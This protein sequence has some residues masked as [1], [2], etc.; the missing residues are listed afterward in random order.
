MIKHF[1][2][3]NIDFKLCVVQVSINF[4]NNYRT[5]SE[6]WQNIVVLQIKVQKLFGT[7]KN[8]QNQR[9]SSRKKLHSFVCDTDRIR[10]KKL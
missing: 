8:V 3:G 10:I 2:L 5:S 1:Y 4:D 9:F 7:Y 6:R